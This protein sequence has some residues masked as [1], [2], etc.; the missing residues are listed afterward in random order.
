MHIP[1]LVSNE[2]MSTVIPQPDWPKWFWQQAVRTNQIIPIYDMGN[3]INQLN[4][5]MRT[6][7]VD[8]YCSPNTL[9]EL[10][11][12]NLEVKANK[13]FKVPVDILPFPVVRCL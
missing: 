10:A 13:S 5:I 6:L 1:T 8:E 3:L 12:S 9:K 7:G 2:L 11:F 4:P